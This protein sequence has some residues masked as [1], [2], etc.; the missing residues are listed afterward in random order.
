MA[1]RQPIDFAWFLEL[2]PFVE[3]YRTFCLAP[4]PEMRLIFHQFKEPDPRK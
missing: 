4:A 2:A 1:P 3:T